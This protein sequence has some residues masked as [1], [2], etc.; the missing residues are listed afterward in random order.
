MIA[1]IV[2]LVC[3]LAGTILCN[4]GSGH[5][6]ELNTTDDWYYDIENITEF[7]IRSYTFLNTFSC[8]LSMDY[9][10][11]GPDSKEIHAIQSFSN[12]IS[13]MR[14]NDEIKPNHDTQKLNGAAFN[15]VLDSTGRIE[16]CV[17][18]DDF[19]QEAKTVIKNRVLAAAK[20]NKPIRCVTSPE[21]PSRRI[22]GG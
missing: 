12:V 18:V 7:E 2:I 17:G 16:S 4:D 13:S 21:S 10:D 11:S 15:I 9:K 20:K 6:F 5:V 19:S 22:S 14:R 8:R 1:R 3:V